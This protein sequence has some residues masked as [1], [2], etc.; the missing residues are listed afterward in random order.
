LFEEINDNKLDMFNLSE[1]FK[2]ILFAHY[3]PNWVISLSEL[4][5]KFYYEKQDQQKKVKSLYNY[6][7]AKFCTVNNKNLYNESWIELL[8]MVSGIEYVVL[9]FIFQKIIKRKLN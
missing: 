9:N 8:N 2:K 3:N 6:K 4:Y 1:H 5:N 7:V